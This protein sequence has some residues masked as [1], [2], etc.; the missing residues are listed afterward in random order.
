MPRIEWVKACLNGGRRRDEHPAVPITAGQLASEAAAAVAAGAEAL[1][2]HPRDQSGEQSV[3]A[4]DVGAAVT[5]V[6]QRCPGV[7][8]GVTTGLW[9]SD[10]DAGK[11]L[12]AVRRWG[13]LPPAARPDF[14]SV[15]VSEPGF[16]ELVDVLEQA[17]IAVEAGVWTPADARDL[18][19]V[20]RTAWFRVLVEVF[21][22]PAEATADTILAALDESGVVG[23]RLL[24]GEDAA[25]WPLVA[26]A[27]RLGLP[28]RIGLEDTLT[29][30]AGEPVTGNADLVRHALAVRSRG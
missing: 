28:T 19:A 7:P 16:A 10:G 29:G 11:R 1:H 13:E 12:A 9:I 8:L 4:D 6:R 15:N 3:W 5:A 23:P 27:A 2:V 30:P 21:D 17:G 26:H 25:C 22:E 24:H 20:G 14:A 18:A